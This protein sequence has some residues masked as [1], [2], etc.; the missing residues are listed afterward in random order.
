MKNKILEDIF[1]YKGGNDLKKNDYRLSGSSFAKWVSTPWSWYREQVLGIDRFEGTT[2]SVLGT[3]VHLAAQA[4]ELGISHI[5]DEVEHQLQEYSYDNPDLD[6]D[7]YEIKHQF[8]LMAEA[9]VDGYLRT[10]PKAEAVEEDLSVEVAD[11]LYAQGSVDR[12]E[13]GMIID[14]KTFNSTTDPKAMPSY[15][16]YQ[17]LFYAWLYLQ[18]GIHID[19]VRLV[20]ISREL[21]TRRISEKTGKPIGKVTPARTVV[22]TEE[23]TVEDLEWV[24]SMVDLWVRTMQLSINH[25]EYRDVL[26]HDPRLREG[27]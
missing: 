22:L 7:V 2:S 19:R 3:C 5:K 24:Q 20:Y 25:P 13:K 23:V 27:K 16:K 9:L 14:Y 8:P 18:K 6:L 11:G 4:Y 15:Y 21:D 1:I 26:W 12:R 10:A 17:V